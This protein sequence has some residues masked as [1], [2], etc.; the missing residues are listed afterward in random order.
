MEKSMSTKIPL[1]I[2]AA[3]RAAVI[4]GLEEF[5]RKMSVKYNGRNGTENRRIR[6]QLFMTVQEYGALTSIS[7]VAHLLAN[8][9]VAK[10]LVVRLAL[11]RL[12]A[13]ALAAMKDP[14][15]AE[16]LKADLL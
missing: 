5:K 11:T 14:V 3:Q 16:R 10:S 13:D 8:R 15:A 6:H 4:E 9:P 2:A 1:T 12:L 7:A